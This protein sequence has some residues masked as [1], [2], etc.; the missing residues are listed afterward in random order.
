LLRDI[1]TSIYALKMLRPGQ[2]SPLPPWLRHCLQD[3]IVSLLQVMH[4]QPNILKS[5]QATKTVMLTYTSKQ[6]S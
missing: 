3:R 5:K 6:K 2:M 4:S 1:P